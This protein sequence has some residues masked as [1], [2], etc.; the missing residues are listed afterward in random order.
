MNEQTLEPHDGFLRLAADL[1][2]AMRALGQAPLA[3]L[4]GVQWA[5]E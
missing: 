1:A 2:G 4:A 5:A 3:L